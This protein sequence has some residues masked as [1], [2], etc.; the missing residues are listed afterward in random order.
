MSHCEI[1]DQYLDKLY[2]DMLREEA[3]LLNSLRTS[4][5]MEVDDRSIQR[6]AQLL[7]S[8]ANN[9]LKLKLCRKKARAKFG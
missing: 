1:T 4:S 3:R 9:A 6:E 8:I 7:H 2:D 5:D